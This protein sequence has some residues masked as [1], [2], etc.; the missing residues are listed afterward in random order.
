MRRAQELNVCVERVVLGELQWQ[1]E[2]EETVIQ[3]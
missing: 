1:Q 2:V 3:L